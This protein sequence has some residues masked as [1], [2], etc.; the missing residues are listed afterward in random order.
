M[1]KIDREIVNIMQHNFPL[2]TQP[3]LE[4]AGYLGISE[5]EV[6]KRVQLLKNEGI[7]RRIGAIL[8][9]KQMGYYSTLCACQVEEGLINE[10]AGVINA[11]KGVTHNYVRD[12]HY[13]IWFTITAPSYEEAMEIIKDIEMA[14]GIKVVTMPAIKMYKIKVCLSLGD[15]DED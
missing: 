13:N 11:Q 4:L 8:D 14:V 10:V 2:S 5:D 3:Y 7:I 9:S 1:D 12:H 15:Y 6:L